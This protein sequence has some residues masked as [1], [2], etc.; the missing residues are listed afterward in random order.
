MR[1]ALARAQQ[2]GEVSHDPAEVLAWKRA[3]RA[4]RGKDPHG[5]AEWRRFEP[6]A[7]VQGPVAPMQATLTME[8]EYN[9]SWLW[10]DSLQ[11]QTTG[12]GD[13]SLARDLD[14]WR[15]QSTGAFVIFTV[16]PRGPNPI[17]DS[18]LTVRNGNGDPVAF[19]DAPGNDSLGLY[20]PAG[21]YII[22]VGSWLDT[23]GLGP[24]HGGAYDLVITTDPL[25]TGAP[26]PLGPLGA[27][28]VTRRPGTGVQD[29]FT[30]NVPEGTLNV[31]LGGGDT[32]L[33][34]QRSDGALLF[35]DDD[36]TVGGLASAF[37]IDLPAGTYYLYAIDFAGQGGLPYTV[38]FAHTPHPL[39]DIAANPTLQGTLQGD[40][41][42]RMYRLS[43]PA[44]QGIDTLTS[45]GGFPAV[46][47]TVL[48][49]YD[50]Q[51]CYLCDVDDDHSGVPPRG[52]YSR[53]TASLFQA[54]YFVGVAPYPGNAGG[55]TLTT[56]V[57]LPFAPAG[58]AH[59]DSNTLQV[60]GLG[61][62]N[63]YLLDCPSTASV[64]FRPDAAFCNVMGPGGR[65]CGTLPGQDWYAQAFE[66][67]RGRSM[68]LA[69]DRYGWPGTLHLDL[70]PTLCCEQNQL[71][72]QLVAY[73]KEG[74]LVFLF[75][76]VGT[77]TGVN[78]GIGDRGWF[79]LGYPSA[80]VVTVGLQ[81][82]APTGRTL[83]LNCPPTPVGVW[84]QQA[85]LHTGL[86][87]SPPFLG[88]WRN[89]R[90]L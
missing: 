68:V 82:V 49:L 81:A 83:W 54:S 29:V 3:F 42:F 51:L 70:L 53:I 71:V 47:D 72:N 8:H 13:N 73:G 31:V 60:P 9:D 61:Q 6:P 88:T 21:P 77:G 57:G 2:L 86:N 90:Q 36:S 52:Y 34:L 45:A 30:C 10:A 66:L 17:D 22:E 64:R 69:W 55:Y 89:L 79:C 7:P 39:A 38:S 78:F 46:N 14:C 27:T 85:D 11:G 18:T 4:A 1:D 26:R 16:V 43:V 58:N 59:Y 62:V 76:D 5:I 48:A 41:S 65:L 44:D 33:Y 80:T 12:R 23:G 32:V 35:M 75:A 40:E 15:Y 56:T 50:S 24:V 25:N 20:L 37:D 87:W 67:P 63:G 84:F 74:D 19:V 28:G